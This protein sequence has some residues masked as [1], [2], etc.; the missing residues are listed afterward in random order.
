MARRLRPTACLQVVY[1]NPK[2][3]QRILRRRARRV[4]RERRRLLPRRLTVPIEPAF[5]QS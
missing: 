3:Y 4:D 1:V 5:T 2:Q